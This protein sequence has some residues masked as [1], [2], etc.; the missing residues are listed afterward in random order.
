MKTGWTTERKPRIIL[1]DFSHPRCRTIALVE[2]KSMPG[3]VSS[4]ACIII[5]VADISVLYL[6]YLFSVKSNDCLWPSIIA[7]II[8][9]ETWT[10]LTDR[11]YLAII[12]EA[13]LALTVKSNFQ[14]VTNET[15]VSIYYDGQY[16]WWKLTFIVTKAG[17]AWVF[18]HFISWCLCDKTVYLT[19]YFS[20][21][22]QCQCIDFKEG[23]R[24]IWL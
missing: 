5:L 4:K 6:N 11:P 9:I 10:Y 3:P 2:V 19:L 14:K 20:E 1:R 16:E 24:G 8:M 22:Y 12:T 18:Q 15:H 23:R 21:V 7:R 17:I 13:A